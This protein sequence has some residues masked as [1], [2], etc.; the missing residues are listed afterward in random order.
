MTPS[1]SSTTKTI[2]SHFYLQQFP[3]I[4]GVTDL[5]VD[6][7]SLTH[8][9]ASTH[10]VQLKSV[11]G[12]P[13]SMRRSEPLAADGSIPCG[14]IPMFSYLHSCDRRVTA[15]L[16]MPVSGCESSP[17]YRGEMNHMAFA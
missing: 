8:T 12:I 14:V 13:C 7:P 4:L 9:H 16:P 2:S 10:P 11:D 5:C 17:I 15:L 3:T 6:S 1:A